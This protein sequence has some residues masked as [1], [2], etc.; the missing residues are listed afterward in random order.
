MSIWYLL[1]SIQIQIVLRKCFYR[2]FWMARF[3][4]PT[5]YSRCCFC[6]PVF[7]H[8]TNVFLLLCYTEWQG[9]WKVNK[10]IHN[11]LKWLNS[12]SVYVHVHLY[13]Y[14]STWLRFCNC[15]FSISVPDF[16]F[17]AHDLESALSLLHFSASLHLPSP[18]L[19]TFTYT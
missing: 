11:Y 17:L 13:L 6:Q 8:A 7:S 12:I 16:P 19:F 4:N 1:Y 14:L 5:I 9:R 10:S 3:W 18:L 15:Q 2:A